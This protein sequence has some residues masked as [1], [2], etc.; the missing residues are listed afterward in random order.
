M[1]LYLTDV[2]RARLSRALGMPVGP[3]LGYGSFG[4]VFPTEPPWIIKVTVDEAEAHTWAEWQKLDRAEYP[5]L[6]VVQR[7]HRLVWRET[8]GGETWV[9]VPDTG[10]WVIVREEA[11]SSLTESSAEK[12]LWNRYGSTFAAVKAAGRVAYNEA[13]YRSEWYRETIE[14]L[15]ESSELNRDHEVFLL[16]ATLLRFASEGKVFP[17]LHPRNLGFRLFAELGPPCLMIIDPSVGPGRGRIGE[18]LVA[19]P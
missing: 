2:E 11:K 4:A 3:R 15:L 13:D 12:D 9:K 10:T 19:N 17:D 8:I 18:D 1:G 14:H 7:V 6:P 16:A 5:A